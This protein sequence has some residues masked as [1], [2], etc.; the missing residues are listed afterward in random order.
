MEESN[1]LQIYTLYSVGG[2]LQCLLQVSHY[3]PFHPD[4]RVLAPGTRDHGDLHTL[5]IQADD[6]PHSQPTEA[7]TTNLCFGTALAPFISSFILVGNRAVG[8]RSGR[9]WKTMASGP[10]LQLSACDCQVLWKHTTSNLYNITCG[11]FHA[12]TAEVNSCERNCRAPKAQIIGLLWKKFV[13]SYPKDWRRQSSNLQGLQP[14]GADR[15][16]NG[17]VGCDKSKITTERSIREIL[18]NC[19]GGADVWVSPWWER[20]SIRQ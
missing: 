6:P 7:V 18:Q 11:W 1:V 12:T 16:T 8:S 5:H 17:Q 4:L 9:G 20:I 13:D 14:H 2:L 19:L 15:L 3:L 10:N